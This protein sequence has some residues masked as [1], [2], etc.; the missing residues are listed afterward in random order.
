MGSNLHR[1]GTIFFLF[2]L[3]NKISTAQNKVFYSGLPNYS[4]D[5]MTIYYHNT[6]D[7]SIMIL[8]SGKKMILFNSDNR[9]DNINKNSIKFLPKLSNT[10]KLLSNKNKVNQKFKFKKGFKNLIIEFD[11]KNYFLTFN[12]DVILFEPN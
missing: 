1:I 8:N 2:C 5:T 7:S 6:S 10:I 9:H 12:N 4:N 11:K 3:L